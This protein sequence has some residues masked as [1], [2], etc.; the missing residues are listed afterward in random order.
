MFRLL[1]QPVCPELNHFDLERDTMQFLRGKVWDLQQGKAHLRKD[2]HGALR[3]QPCSLHDRELHDREHIISGYGECK[4]GEV[5]AGIC[6]ENLFDAK[7][8]NRISKLRFNSSTKPTTFFPS[9]PVDG[10]S[11]WVIKTDIGS[12]TFSLHCAKPEIQGFDHA[13]WEEQ[14]K[15]HCTVCRMPFTML[16][17]FDTAANFQELNLGTIAAKRKSDR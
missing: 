2:D 17:A 9:P 13:R 5:T 14:G 10:D 4:P 6:S 11:C 3:N 12:R 16:T 8:W 7:R 15:M 1:F